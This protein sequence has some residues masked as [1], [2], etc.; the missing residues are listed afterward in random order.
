MSLKYIFANLDKVKKFDFSSPIEVKQ[1]WKEKAKWLFSFLFPTLEKLLDNDK[2]L[3]YKDGKLF[4]KWKISL[5]VENELCEIY[6][7]NEE[8]MMDIYNKIKDKYD[9]DI[10]K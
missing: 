2:S 1:N 8:D 6:F 7:D 9:L 3:F 4:K 10:F 5:F